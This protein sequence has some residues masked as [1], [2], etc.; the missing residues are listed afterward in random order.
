[1]EEAQVHKVFIGDIPENLTVSDLNDKLKAY[2]GVEITVLRSSNPRG[3]PFTIVSVPS[4]EA[5]EKMKTELNGHQWGEKILT[6]DDARPPRPRRS[7]PNKR[8]FNRRRQS[9]PQEGSQTETPEAP[10]ENRKQVRKPGRNTFFQ[11]LYKRRM[12]RIRASDKP[13]TQKTPNDGTS[14]FIQNLPWSFTEEAIQSWVESHKLSVEHVKLLTLRYF[15]RR[16]Q[17]FVTKSMGKGFLKFKTVEEA[18]DFLENYN[19]KDIGGRMLFASLARSGPRVP[20]EA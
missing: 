17:A 10:S 11:T 8:Q 12:E 2:D 6:V 1:M 16:L 7:V 5:K 14:I 13:K 9:T 3:K 4:A 19:K 15:D 20:I 18:K